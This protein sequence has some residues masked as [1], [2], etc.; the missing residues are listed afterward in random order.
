[1]PDRSCDR[2]GAAKTSSSSPVPAWNNARIW[3]TGKPQPVAWLPGWPKWARSAGV[4]DMENAE[5]SIR[6]GAGRTSGRRPGCR[7]SGS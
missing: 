5:P 4:S 2:K 6:R 7:G 3:A 1:M